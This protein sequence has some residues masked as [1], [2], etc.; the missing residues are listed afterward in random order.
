[1]L[2]FAQTVH[3]ACKIP[4]QSHNVLYSGTRN[5]EIIVGF[6]KDRG[7]IRM[8]QKWQRIIQMF[9]SQSTYLNR[10]VAFTMLICLSKNLLWAR[11]LLVFSYLLNIPHIC[12][13]FFSP[14]CIV[15]N[16]TSSLLS[17]YNSTQESNRALPYP[18]ENILEF[19]IL[20][21]SI[22]LETTCWNYH[23]SLMV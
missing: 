4:F 14:L 12:Y 5:R 9:Q 18:P 1:M 8:W 11:A 21:N 17:Y 6:T 2:N 16:P 22:W 19:L 20:Y 15:I 23:S 10:N 7:M 3:W 13:A